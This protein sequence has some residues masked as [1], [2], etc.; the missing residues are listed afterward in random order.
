MH[1]MRLR[2]QLAALAL[3]ALA[4]ACNG[5]SSTAP[6]VDIT[7]VNFASS[8]GISL[9]SMNKTADGLYFQDTPTGTGATASKGDTLTVNYTGYFTNGTSFD[10][11][12]GKVPL[13]FKL[14]AGQV[15]AGWE[16]G[17]AGMKVGGT[18]KLVIPPALGYGSSGSGSIPGNTILV[19]TV[20]LLSIP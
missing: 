15:I 2:V 11:S 4:L 13:K 7:T 6:S 19:F 12:V 17:L 18:R 10:S 14:G 1:T 20:Q 16:E 9:A 8:L 3:A 5:D